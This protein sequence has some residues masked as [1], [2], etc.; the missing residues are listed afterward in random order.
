[1][2]I[3][4]PNINTNERALW[5]AGE[6]AKRFNRFN[7]SLQ[8]RFDI[9]G[10]PLIE[11]E[12]YIKAHD[13]KLN[14]IST[15]QNDFWVTSVTENHESGKYYN[16]IEVESLKPWQSFFR[17]PSPSLKRL[18]N[19]VF[20]NV[21][22]YNTGAHSYKNDEFCKLDTVTKSAGKVATLHVR[23]YRVNIPSLDGTSEVEQVFPPQGFLKIKTEIIQYN[24]REFKNLISGGKPN[25]N[26]PQGY[27]IYQFDVGKLTRGLYATSTLAIATLNNTEGPLLMD[28]CT[29]P[30][31]QETLGVTPAIEFDLLFP[32]HVQVS[33]RSNEGNLLDSLT[34]AEAPQFENNWEFLQPGKY[35]FAWGMFDRL[36]RHNEVNSWISRYSG[37]PIDIPGAPLS[38]LAPDDSITLDGG[39]FSRPPAFGA[40]EYLIGQGYY[41]QNQFKRQ[42]S[43]HNFHVRYRDKSQE[44]FSGE[45]T[46][47]GTRPIYLAL[48]RDGRGV[49]VL[50]GQRTNERI[51]ISD[52]SIMSKVGTGTK[53][54]NNTLATFLK[55]AWA[56]TYKRFYSGEENEGRGLRINLKNKFSNVQRICKLKVERHIF[57]IVEKYYSGWK[58]GSTGGKYGDP[59]T[60]PVLVDTL[61]DSLIDDTTF[62]YGIDGSSGLNIYLKAPDVGFLTPAIQ[63]KINSQIGEGIG[64][65]G[66]DIHPDIIYYIAVTHVHFIRCRATDM[67][68]IFDDFNFSILWLPNQYHNTKADFLAGDTKKSLYDGQPFEAADFLPRGTFGA[69]VQFELPFRYSEAFPPFSYVHENKLVLQPRH[70]VGITVYGKY[71]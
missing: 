17:Y 56:S 46:I 21:K 71:S 25:P 27:F 32:G 10:N 3:I 35:F 36:G 37:G 44:H 34:G 13:L 63:G 54:Y 4:D 39:R 16:N 69:P 57:T 19:T 1:M 41:A 18:G 7:K 33:V 64:Q 49:G 38:A 70:L 26:N 45:D 62:N 53:W 2:M 68:G 65:V 14:T 59:I 47:K 51:I 52:N 8:P 20:R 15:M 11:V 48:R 40:W 60:E 29:S 31:S 28:F 50:S 30:Y 6:T 22:V 55:P 42:Y 67:S 58:V 43:A 61:T 24:K 5:L 66:G 9:I 23:Y 12:D